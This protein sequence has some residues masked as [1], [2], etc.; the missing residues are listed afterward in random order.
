MSR[1]PGFFI[2]GAAKA[3]TTT[4]ANLL[5]AHPQVGIVRGKEPHFFSVDANYQSGLQAY[6]RLY[7]H[8]AQKKILG[9]A[10]TSYS[11][12]RNHPDVARRIHLAVPDARIIYMVRQP[13]KR[14][15]SAYIERMA[16]AARRER[17][18]SINEAVLSQPTLI[19]S[20]RYWEVYT[21]YLELFGAKRI[22]IVW[23]EDFISDMDSAYR[24]VCRFLCIDEQ[25]PPARGVN[26][27]SRA[28]VHRRIQLLGR[29]HWSLDISWDTSTLHWVLGQLKEDTRQLLHHFGKPENY[30][31]DAGIP[32]HLAD[33]SS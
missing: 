15:E 23:Y 19:D 6:Q 14:I 4:L 29:G 32:P 25:S 13:L 8:C 26:G 16:T 21:H 17:W 3:A 12:I 18:S 10:S 20:S 27:N 31:G 5:A 2:I 9:D 30:W 1:L 22:H 33:K 7:R 11:R 28:D 24:E